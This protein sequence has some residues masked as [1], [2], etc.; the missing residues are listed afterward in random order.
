MVSL[1]NKSRFVENSSGSQNVLNYESQVFKRILKS[2]VA[3][4]NPHKI[5]NIS[6]DTLRYLDIYIQ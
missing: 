3:R 5:R 1:A 2:V 6:S 4:Y